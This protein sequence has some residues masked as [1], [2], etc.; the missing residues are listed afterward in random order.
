M[1]LS[2]AL[3]PFPATRGLKYNIRATAAFRQNGNDGQLALA[4]WPE[5]ALRWCWFLR[6]KNAISMI[7]RRLEIHLKVSHAPEFTYIFANGLPAQSEVRFNFEILKICGDYYNTSGYFIFDERAELFWYILHA[8]Q[9]WPPGKA[10]EWVIR[11]AYRQVE[12][13]YLAFFDAAH[14]ATLFSATFLERFIDKVGLSHNITAS[15]H[16]RIIVTEYLGQVRIDRRSSWRVCTWASL[17]HN[18][19]NM[20]QEPY[21]RFSRQ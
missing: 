14:A 17:S 2:P 10:L 4:Y 8:A 9:N 15:S 6:T 1:R 13:D 20:T 7:S 18:L 5:T 3:M 12:Y 19:G 16:C 21:G 11:S